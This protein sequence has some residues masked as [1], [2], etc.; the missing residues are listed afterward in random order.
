M[1]T[2]TDRERTV[3]TTPS[4]GR[5]QWKAHPR[6]PSQ[7][8]LLGS[9]ENFRNVSEVLVEEAAA[10]GFVRPI[11]SLYR[12]WIAAMRSH[13]AYEEGK[14]YPYLERRFL[15]SLE[16][17]EEGHQEL[18]AAHDDVMEALAE[19]HTED[20]P[21]AGEALHA[22]LRRH[23]EVLRTHLDLEEDL[24]I[25]LLLELSPQE[26]VEYYDKPIDVLLRRLDERSMNT[27][28]EH[29]QTG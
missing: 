7:A 16:A 29:G 22:A 27:E 17:A 14:L 19:A 3:D 15:T 18:H 12:R 26:F 28:A 9:H 5:D 25:P 13:E 24:V 20:E 11:G 1:N 6:F 2:T 10:G 4:L 8:L 23:D 21:R